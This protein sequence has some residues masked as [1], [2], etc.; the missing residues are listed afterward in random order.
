MPRLNNFFRSS[1]LLWLLL[2]P[3]A[4]QASHGANLAYRVTLNGSRPV[5]DAYV[6][7]QTRGAAKTIVT[8][9]DQSGK[10]MVPGVNADKILMTIEKNGRVVYRGIHKVDSTSGE[11]VIDLMERNSKP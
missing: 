1:R 9:T 5:A 7:L 2:A 10:F 8:K 3:L 6:T 4:M 11:K